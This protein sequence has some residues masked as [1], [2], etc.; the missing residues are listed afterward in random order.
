MSSVIPVIARLYEVVYRE[1]PYCEGA[2]DVAELVEGMPRRAAQPAFRLVVATT[3]GKPVGFAFGHQLTADTKWWQG[4]TTPLPDSIVREHAGRTFAI[5][6]LAVAAEYRR[7][8][9]A[10]AMHD[11]L[12]VDAK[13]ERATL[14]VRPEAMP[15]R[16]AYERWGYARVGSIRPWPEAP[17]YDAMMLNLRR[18]G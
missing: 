12:L 15:A 17:L 11:A 8:G 9:I 4:A 10:K 5:I 1:P 14:L 16:T 18:L 13:E 2:E 6:E 3:D 7:R